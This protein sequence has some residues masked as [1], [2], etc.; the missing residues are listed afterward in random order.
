MREKKTPSCTIE[1]EEIW[2][3]SRNLQSV[4]KLQSQLP[5]SGRFRHADAAAEADDILD[6]TGGAEPPRRPKAAL[7]G[8]S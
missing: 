4:E 2:H 5:E 8:V 7:T 6:R 1:A 3:P